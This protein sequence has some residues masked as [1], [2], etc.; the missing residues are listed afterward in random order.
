M[1]K[2]LG[3][4]IKAGIL[5][6]S[7][8]FANPSVTAEEVVKPVKI[9]IENENEVKIEINSKIYSP[10]KEGNLTK[11]PFYYDQ[12]IMDCE[13]EIYPTDPERTTNSRIKK[14]EN[15][16][17]EQKIMSLS[18]LNW[19]FYSEYDIENYKC[20]H[21][22]L[23]TEKVTE[24]IGFEGYVIG[25]MPANTPL[26]HAITLVNTGKE[27]IFINKSD[28]FTTKSK[29]IEKILMQYNKELDEINFITHIFDKGNLKWIPINKN[30][31]RFSEFL[32][33]DYSTN[34]THKKLI[35]LEEKEEK[36]L[37][38]VDTGNYTNSIKLKGGPF[39]TKLGILKGDENSALENLS[40]IQAGYKNSFY[41]N[42]LINLDINGNYN[43]SEAFC[44]KGNK[45]NF[46]GLSGDIN[47]FTNKEKG[48][49]LSLRGGTSFNEIEGAEI[50][51]FYN[52]LIDTGVSYKF[53]N[54]NI[55]LTPYLINQLNGD[56]KDLRKG[57]GELFPKEIVGGI[58]IESQFGSLKT[59]GDLSYSNKLHEHEIKGN[60]NLK[61]GD[62]EFSL[63]GYL[64]KPKF[65]LCPERQGI[66]LGVSTNL[67]NKVNFNLD[68]NQDLVNYQGEKENNYSVSV[69]AN[70]KF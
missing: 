8:L 29:N 25:N 40:I 12:N 23:D 64:A 1:K 13:K 30:G 53:Q 36:F 10:S 38:G 61:K 17:T 48:L 9:E 51:P 6:T 34:P 63:G 35:N 7:L 27:Y 58:N 39:F 47:L 22:S 18:S 37:V 33:Y 20:T 26:S 14:A 32:D 42:D 3:S 11:I 70:I 45:Q 69:G 31:E 44:K 60:L 65:V 57:K 5:G 15:F 66:N 19:S 50:Q 67:E 21:I 41:L 54:K 24:K 55:S 4:I 52:I 68:Y 16:S 2:S 62:L 59:E 49:N 56:V 28:I 43:H 46:N